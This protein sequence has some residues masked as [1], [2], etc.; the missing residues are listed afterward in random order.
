MANSGKFGY[1][2][3][4]SFR[5]PRQGPS[6]WLGILIPSF[7]ILTLFPASML[8]YWYPQLEGLILDL[9]TREVRERTDQMA[10]WISRTGN[11][12]SIRGVVRDFRYGPEDRNYFWLLSRSHRLLVHPYRPDLL[13]RDMRDYQDPDGVFLFREIVNT[14][15]ERGSGFVEYRWQLFGEE[16]TS[17]RKK[18]YVRG[19]PGTDWILGT[20]IYLKPQRSQVRDLMNRF[21]LFTL[22]TILLLAGL[23]GWIV[24]TARKREKRDRIMQENLRRSETRYRQ[25]VEKMR[26]GLMIKDPLESIRYVNPR[27]AEMVGYPSGDI[28]GKNPADFLAPSSLPSYRKAMEERREGREAGYELVWLSS[29]GE[30]VDTHVSPKIL[31]DS[32]GNR[33]GSFAVVTD[34][35]PLKKALREKDILL[36]EIHHRVKNNLQTITSLLNLQMDDARLT[37]DSRELLRATGNRVQAMAQIHETLYS[38]QELAGIS[39]GGY[40][41]EMVS[42]LDESFGL[43]PPVHITWEEADPATLPPVHAVPLGLILNEVLTN[44]YKHAFPPLKERRLWISYKTRDGGIEV[45]VADNGPGRPEDYSQPASSRG[46]LGH[47]LIQ[48]LTEQLN[49]SWHTAARR[50]GG[51][52]ITFTIPLQEPA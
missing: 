7:L 43:N 30:R 1:T 5:L 48:A 19:I 38:S 33:E 37:A 52:V 35:T 28:I 6:S 9:D 31:R 39:L 46:G 2:Y 21:S 26:D 47:L 42:R 15:E 14:V 3:P 8:F 18:S 13:N 45:S 44:T 4:M 27:F 23:V 10:F 24:I 32:R 20:G 16:E 50:G 51:L 49:G 25:L 22:G 40:I 29:R 34:I 17:L 12:D 11:L 41:R 36:R